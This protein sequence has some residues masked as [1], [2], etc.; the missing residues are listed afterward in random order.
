[1]RVDRRLFVQ[2]QTRGRLFFR[3]GCHVNGYVADD[4][5]RPRAVW[6]AKR[7]LSKPT[8]PGLLDQMAAGGLPA[9][10]TFLENARK[11]AQEEASL[12]SDVLDS[13]RPAGCVS[14]KY[15]ARR[16]LSAK[17]LAVRTTRVECC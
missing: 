3:Y 12:P 16:G 10:T 15:A 14:Y 11:E 13:L 6:L 2:T 1:M 4:R 5:G 7:A 9:S 17:T 8:Y